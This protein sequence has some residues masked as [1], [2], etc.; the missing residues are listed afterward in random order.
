MLKRVAA[1]TEVKLYVIL[2][3]YFIYFFQIYN[4]YFIYFH[5]L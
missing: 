4:L 2:L 1:P 5:D 3:F